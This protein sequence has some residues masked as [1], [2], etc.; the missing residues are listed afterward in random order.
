MMSTTLDNVRRNTALLV[1]MATVSDKPAFDM[2]QI[3]FEGMRIASMNEGEC[4][5]VICRVRP[6]IGE[7]VSL[8]S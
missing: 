1:W 4:Y 7:V 2:E 8:V 6:D 3:A 5:R